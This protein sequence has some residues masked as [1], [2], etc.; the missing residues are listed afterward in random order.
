MLINP[1]T[2][3]HSQKPNKQCTLELFCW[4]MLPSVREVIGISIDPIPINLAPCTNDWAFAMNQQ[5]VD[6]KNVK[7]KGAYPVNTIYDTPATSQT[8]IRHRQ[9]YGRAIS[10]AC[11]CL[12]EC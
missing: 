6:I 12:S 3:Q 1:S 11:A 7:T 9:K 2:K 8:V 10:L 5:V 4:R